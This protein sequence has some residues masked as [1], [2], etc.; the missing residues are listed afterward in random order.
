MDSLGTHIAIIKQAPLFIFIADHTHTAKWV[1]GVANL[2][3]LLLPFSFSFL[4]TRK[5]EN[6]C[7]KSGWS[8]FDPLDLLILI[9]L[10]F[11]CNYQWAARK[12]S[13]KPNNDNCFDILDQRSIHWWH[14]SNTTRSSFH[15]S[16]PPS[17]QSR[18]QISPQ[19][20]KVLIFFIIIF[21]SSLFI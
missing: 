1:S 3:L 19:P 20:L 6:K 12:F 13:I 4:L 14:W 18:S 17:D 10:S 7:H 15:A 11:L 21:F 16:N 9:R 5:G 2:A 8:G